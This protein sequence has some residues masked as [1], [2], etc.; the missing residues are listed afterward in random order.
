MTDKI[1]EAVQEFTIFSKTF[2]NAVRNFYNVKTT[3]YE[4]AK[5]ELMP[6]EGSIFLPNE[7]ELSFRLH[8]IGCEFKTK[9]ITI[10]VN[11]AYTNIELYLISGYNFSKFLNFSEN[12][13]EC[14]VALNS[15]AEKGLLKMYL[16]YF[17]LI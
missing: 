1:L 8:G 14:F 5:A 6:Y 2:T 16:G 11:Y 10:D 13:Q 9:A 3:L 4:A 7:E 17:Y 15:L 12:E